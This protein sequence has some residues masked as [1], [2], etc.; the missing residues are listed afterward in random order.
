MKRK[1][2][3]TLVEMIA[4]IAMLTIILGGFGSLVLTG[5]KQNSINSKL[6]DSYDISK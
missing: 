1:K 5:Y 6:L 2:G 4:A 3:F